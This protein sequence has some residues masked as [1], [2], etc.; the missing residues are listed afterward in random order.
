MAVRTEYIFRINQ[1]YTLTAAD[2]AEIAADNA[3]AKKWDKGYKEFKS[4][5]RTHLRLQ[6]NGRCAFCRCRVSIGTSFSNLEHLISKT[7][8]V[9]F[10]TTPDNLVYSCTKCNLSKNK[11]ATIN[12]PNPVPAQQQFPATANDFLIVNPYHDDYEQHIDFIDD[13]LIQ[14]QD[15]S[16][17]GTTTITYYGL[18]R[19]ELA[20]ERACE[21]K[22]NQQSLN[23]QLLER[24]THPSTTPEIQNQINAIV[25]NMP[26]WTL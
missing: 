11:K 8:Y 4:S 14:P 13:V 19:P 10:K 26:N 5:I 20:E 17:K 18:A 1:R 22:L 7:D 16:P 23:H 3:S 25:A 21:F 15:N 2:Q 9:Q 12:N 24:L 6:Q